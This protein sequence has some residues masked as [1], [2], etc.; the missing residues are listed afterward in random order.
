MNNP[1]EVRAEIVE[2][3]RRELVGPDPGYPAIQINREEIL[4]PQDPPRLR[5]S[6]GVLFPM[7]AQVQQAEVATDE[8]VNAAE[9]APAEGDEPEEETSSNS[10]RGELD[11]FPEQEVN[12]ANEYLPSA[13]GLSALVLLPKFLKVKV[14]AG[15]Y[16]KMAVSGLGRQDAKG[17]FLDHY[18]RSKI[19][20]EQLIDCSPFLVNKPVVAKYELE[21]GSAES[22]LEF[23]LFSRLHVHGTNTD[24]ERIITFTL[25]NRNAS[26]TGKPKDENCFFQC[27][28]EVMDADGGSCF[29][30]YPERIGESED[31]EEASLRLLYRHRKTFAV[32]HGCAANWPDGE[33]TTTNRIWT[34][35]LPT[36]EVKPIL[37]NEIEGL[38]LAMQQLADEKDDKALQLCRRLADEYLA[39]IESREKE[40][41]NPSF[42]TD[43]KNTA[44]KHLQKCRDCHKRIVTGVS[45]LQQ[46]KIR[47]A[48]AWMNQ[49][50]LQQQVHYDLA[51]NHK[52]EWKAR[53]G[54]LV[55][56]K[57][58]QPPDLSNPGPTRGKWR[59]FQLAFILMNLRAMTQPDCDER[60]I[61]DLIWF[62]TGGGKT[63]AY[64]GLTAF[65]LFWRR[66]TNPDNCG[67]T[68]LMRYTLRLLTTQQFQRAASLIC[69]C[70]LIRRSHL[71]ILGSAP[72][73]IGLWVGGEVTPNKQSEGDRSAVKALQKLLNGEPENLFILLNCPWCGA[74]MGP[75]KS[76]RG[77][78]TPGYKLKAAPRRVEFCC[79]DQNCDFSGNDGLPVHVIDEAIYQHRPTLVIG[80]VDK[81]ALLPWY[82]EARSLFGLDTA[83]A[84]SPPDLIIQDELHLI[85]GA[86]GSMV[87]HYEGTLDALC[88][89]D[90]DG[91]KI[92]AKIVASTATICRAQEQVRALYAREVSLFPPQALRAGDS[93]FAIEKTEVPGRVY[94][95]V[96]ASAL[97]SHVTAQIRVMAALLQA[98]KCCEVSDPA[99]LDP[100]WTLM[101]YFNSLRELGHAATLIRADI[102]EYLNAVWDRLNIRRPEPDSNEPDRRRFINRDLELTSRIQSVRISEALQ[103]LFEPHTGESNERVVDV[104]LATNM[105]QVGLDVPRLGLMTVVGQPKTT[106]EYIQAT[107][108][109]GRSDSGPGLVVTV[110]NVAKP[111]DRS[112]YEH[113][114]SYHQ[115]FYRWVEPTSV[116]PFAIPVLERALHAQIVTLARYW[117]DEEVRRRPQPAPPD[118]LFQEI[119]KLILQRVQAVDPEEFDSTKKVL[120][121]VVGN[122]RLIPPPLYGH[123]GPPL[124]QTPLMY[125]SG[126]QVRTEWDGRS[127]PTPS[128]MRNV[129]AGCEAGVVRNYIYNED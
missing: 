113:F 127:L 12:R 94:I 29:L 106:S 57:S 63:E 10:A 39:W 93:F 76:G 109:V 26:E 6:A 2:F 92:P 35:T 108:R 78:K 4:R 38:E 28:F 126:S 77:T 102:R 19:E 97:S 99:L 33:L 42:P 67:T 46:P 37:P 80:T 122:W 20:S 105:I 9:S 104:C 74:Q 7:K 5:Y 73:S 62:P 34:E 23:H 22:K 18:W 49:A 84:I 85:S 45:L 114:R 47:R 36:Y 65:T 91:R 59:P 71:E 119:E 8:E 79:E 60:K 66:I 11:E 1:A 13:M 61:V 54:E 25:I 103:Q 83:G 58:Y 44:E 70:E 111:R 98:V 72:I 110:Y 27:H 43:L 68:V 51:A 40:V 52:R 121:E 3:L 82:P 86:L 53:D 100:Y 123:F 120:E 32:G 118:A 48:F 112:H 30:E 95:G 88:T 115:S 69:A 31:E 50:M 17:N 101:A 21:T 117:G 89:R 125:P 96:F 90:A 107:S 55:L 56:E 124:D 129:D 81:F 16:E 64:L 24:R 15:R 14:S 116:T 75:V 128:S 41:R 87:G